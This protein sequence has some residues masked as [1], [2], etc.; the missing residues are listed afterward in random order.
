MI[1][2]ACNECT[3]L[4]PEASAPAVL[5]VLKVA[6]FDVKALLSYR[7][8]LRLCSQMFQ[9]ASTSLLLL[10]CCA[11]QLGHTSHTY[12]ALYHSSGFFI[13]VSPA[14][15]W[16]FTALVHNFNITPNG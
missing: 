10:S 3:K 12:T 6:D 5:S 1:L 16:H 11:R 15:G 9:H 13:I 4:E 2:P 8:E 14:E 7:S